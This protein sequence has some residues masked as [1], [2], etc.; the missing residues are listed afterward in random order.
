E[1]HALKEAD[2]AF[3]EVNVMTD[4]HFRK[5]IKENRAELDKMF[6]DLAKDEKLAGSHLAS[7]E[8]MVDKEMQKEMQ[9]QM[10]EFMNTVH[11]AHMQLKKLKDGKKLSREEEDERR[12]L[13]IAR[14][15]Q[16]RIDTDLPIPGKA[17]SA[18]KPAPTQAPE[19]KEE[20]PK[21]D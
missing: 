3:K 4:D 13:M 2:K 17:T 11:M 7:L 10:A 9:A 21:K 16:A 14:A 19:K 8:A 18:T 15:L 5:F 6:K 1:E 20:S 12:L